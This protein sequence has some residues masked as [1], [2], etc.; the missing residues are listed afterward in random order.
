[1]KDLEQ[2]R[3]AFTEQR[4]APVGLQSGVFQEL[5]KQRVNGYN[6]QPPPAPAIAPQVT[7]SGGHYENDGHNHSGGAGGL[8]PQFNAAVQRMLKDAP[9]GISITSGFR[10]PEKQAQLWANALKKY[11]SAAA[12]RKW[13]APPG[14]SNHG[15]GIAMDLRF[16]SPTVRQWVHANAA[17]YGLHFPMSWEPWHVE[18]RGSR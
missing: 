11:G 6:Y 10:S 1:M 5:L 7:P 13:V 12:A 16:A 17:R 3:Q 4:R 9:G 15:R 18:L 14:K 2:L 8:N